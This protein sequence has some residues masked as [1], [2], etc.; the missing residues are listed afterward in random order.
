M[1][2]LKAKPSSIKWTDLTLREYKSLLESKR[3]AHTTQCDVTE[4][5][6]SLFQ[7]AA[8]T[9]ITCPDGR[10]PKA[11]D[12]DRDRQPDK[13]AY[14]YR[15]ISSGARSEGDTGSKVASHKSTANR[16]DGFLRCI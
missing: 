15:R 13:D 11:D 7:T 3:K 9:S 8:H 12:T 6:R 10:D 14:K 4:C 2:Y 5:R 1:A 16:A